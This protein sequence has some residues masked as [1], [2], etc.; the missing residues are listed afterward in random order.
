MFIE[1]E[2]TP[3]PATIRFLPGRPVLE[4][5]TVEFAD[6][7]LAER[8]PLARRLFAIAPVRRVALGP[9]YIT[10]TKAEKADWRDLKPE[11]LAAIMQHFLAGEPVMGPAEPDFEAEP[12][13]AEVVEELRNLIETRI[14]PTAAERG[15]DVVFRGYRDGVVYLEF[16]GAGVALRGAIANMLRH[17]VPEVLDVRDWRDALPRPGLDTPEGRTILRLLDERINPAVVA[18][19]GHVALVDVKDDTAFIRLEGGCQGCGMAD[20]TLKQGIEFEIM[21]AVPTITS[22]LDVTDHAGGKNPYYQPGKGGA[23]PF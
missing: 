12:E 18:H 5:R 19:G 14:Q 17:Y 8:S 22:V 16:Q 20:V 3:D 7:A 13:D 6:P 1:T 11:V 9:D 2:R 10:V 21:R 23:S 4:T 15:G